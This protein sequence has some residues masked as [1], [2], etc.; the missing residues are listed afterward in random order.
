MK[1]QPFDFPNE[2]YRMS[3][4]EALRRHKRSEVFRHPLF[5]LAEL[6]DPLEPEHPFI[7]Q[8]PLPYVES[9]WHFSHLAIPEWIALATGRKARERS[10]ANVVKEYNLSPAERF[11]RVAGAVRAAQYS[12]TD[13]ETW[14]SEFF[15]SVRVPAEFTSMGIPIYWVGNRAWALTNREIRPWFFDPRAEVLHGE[16][17]LSLA[18]EIWGSR[19]RDGAPQ[20]ST[21]PSNRLSKIQGED[22]PT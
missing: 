12:T 22:D 20:A 15:C 3:L 21:S 9:Q 2:L 1:S 7:M 5:A 19:I 11:R 6:F 8:G 4:G 18:R 16:K 14:H 13:P 10:I 17:A